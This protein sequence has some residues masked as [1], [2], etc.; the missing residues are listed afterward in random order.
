MK[1]VNI[2]TLTPAKAIH[3]GTILKKEINFRKIKQKDLAGELGIASTQLNDILAGKRKISTEIAILLEAALDINAI[4]WMN[5]QIK[6]DITVAKLDDAIQKKAEEVQLWKTLKARIPFSFLRKLKV[7]VDDKQKDIATIFRIFDA[8]SVDDIPVIVKLP[9]LVRFK[10]SSTHAVDEVNI[11]GWVQ[12]VKYLAKQK[13]VSSF[14]FDTEAS[15]I[16]E[17]IPLFSQKEVLKNI[18][19]LLAKYGI[20]FIVQAKPDKVPVDGIVFWFENNPVIAV[21]IRHKRLD[22]LAFTILHELGHIFLHLK[23]DKK[24]QFIDDV[25]STKSKEFKEEE[26]ANTYAE[27]KLI[28]QDKWEMLTQNTS[29]FSSGIIKEFAEQINIHPAIALGR[30]KKEQNEYYRRRFSIDNTIY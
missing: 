23:K 18:E 26:E 5:L 16:E 29:N 22:N 9:G 1:Q 24:K 19:I 8:S 12:Y 30:L 6:Y 3:P 13:K 11:R 4:I 17:L 20:I 25:E 2:G 7:L 15:L 10:K 21:T 28:P 14:N 27:N